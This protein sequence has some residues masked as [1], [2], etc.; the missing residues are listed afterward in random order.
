MALTKITSDVI[1]SG[2]IESTHIASGAI[3]SS[4]L[5]GITTDNVSEGSSNTYFTNA[6]ARGAVSVTGGNLSYDS[7]TGVIQLTTGTIRAQLSGGT[8]VTYNSTSGAISIG[9]SV[10]TDA[11]PTFGNTT[12]TGYLRG[13]STFTID[14][15]AHGDNT[16]TVVIAGNLQVDGTTTTI[17]STT[18]TVDDKL[19]T[20]ASGSANAAAANGAGIEVDISGATNPSLLYD[21]TNDQWDF[22]KSLHIVN[23]TTDDTILLE[24]TED[25]N[26]AA[27]VLTFKRHS[28]SP[29]DADYL[30]QLKFRG[31]N[32]ADQ[33]IVY[34]KMTS[35]ISDASD[36]SEDGTLEFAVRKAGSNNINMRLGPNSLQI[37]NGTNLTVGALTSGKTGTLTI[38]N[39]GGNIA[40]LQVLSRTNRSVLRVA[41]ND[42]NGYISAE[43]DIFSIGQNSGLNSAN[44]NIDTSNRVGIGT[45]APSNKLHV[46]GVTNTDG[47]KIQ[48]R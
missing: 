16:G 3:S 36:G 28:S 34:A 33:D 37:I 29:A 31:E 46:A 19:V 1:G 21:G 5:T 4:H 25:S 20:L 22:N 9:Q 40:T 24:S 35:K 7:S 14:P 12:L 32:D 42:T 13:P 18:L 48:G 10:A 26:L 47:I 15:A 23:N 45:T 44:I 41:D 11:T 27:P 6:R 8:G 2:A 17:N 30:G 43:N 39:E 38:N